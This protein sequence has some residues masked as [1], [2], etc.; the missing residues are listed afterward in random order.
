MESNYPTSKT[1]TSSNY[2]TSKAATENCTNR[3]VNPMTAMDSEPLFIDAHRPAR[4][5]R[6][7]IPTTFNGDG[8][9][10]IIVCTYMGMYKVHLHSS[11]PLR[12]PR[13]ERAPVSAG[14][15]ATPAD[16]SPLRHKKSVAGYVHT[17]LHTVD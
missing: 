2:S 9:R 15:G 6:R 8:T 13:I 17:Q 11:A 12:R 4:L 5:I 10:T 14:G 3:T 7:L 1:S 16:R